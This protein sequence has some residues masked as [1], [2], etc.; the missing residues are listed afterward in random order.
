MKTLDPTQ[1]K[2]K[3]RIDELKSG[4]VSAKKSAKKYGGISLSQ[5]VSSYYT[6]IAE[7]KKFLK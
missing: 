2:I 4:L 7:L 6:L 3:A 1:L 5:Q